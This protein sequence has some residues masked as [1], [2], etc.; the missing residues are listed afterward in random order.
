MSMKCLWKTS[1][2]TVGGGSVA[3]SDSKGGSKGDCG[4]YGGGDSR[5]GVDGG[6]DC[7]RRNNKSVLLDRHPGGTKGTAATK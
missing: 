1:V 4:I 6:S 3:V 7:A 5:L 2:V